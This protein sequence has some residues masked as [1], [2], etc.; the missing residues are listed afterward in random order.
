MLPHWGFLDHEP[1]S[2]VRPSS[3][4]CSR[5]SGDISTLCRVN[6][7]DDEWD[8]G[9]LEG[10]QEGKDNNDDEGDY[11]GYLP[12][13]NRCRGAVT[14]LCS[15]SR[16]QITVPSDA[17]AHARA[18][19]HTPRACSHTHCLRLI[20]WLAA[21][22]QHSSWQLAADAK[23]LLTITPTAPPPATLP[24][25]WR[26]HLAIQPLCTP[27]PPP[28]PPCLFSKHIIPFVLLS[29]RFHTPPQGVPPPAPR[30]QILASSAD[31]IDRCDE[32]HE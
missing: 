15:P 32:K 22:A 30:T 4:R 28:P 29:A 10:G 24:V 2:H 16:L 3:S 1:A 20:R 21:T 12:A 27:R 31:L 26:H 6:E 17:R 23:E 5:G 11:C 18:H 8:D 19:V 13:H 7:H 14:A 9:D 25:S